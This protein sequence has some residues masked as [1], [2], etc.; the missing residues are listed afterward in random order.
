MEPKSTIKI[1]YLSTPGIGKKIIQG[2]NKEYKRNS[3]MHVNLNELNDESILKESSKEILKNLLE[4]RISL[5]KDKKNAKIT[6][7]D[8]AKYKSKLIP[9]ARDKA[10]EM[11]LDSCTIKKGNIL[12]LSAV[13]T[14][15]DRMRSND[16]RTAAPEDIMKILRGDVYPTDIWTDFGVVLYKENKDGPNKKHADHL[17]E[18]LDL[19]TNLP[20]L[21]YGLRAHKDKKFPYGVRLDFIPGKSHYFEAPVLFGGTHTPLTR[22]Q[23]IENVLSCPDINEDADLEVYANHSGLMP[24]CMD[25]D[26]NIGAVEENLANNNSMGRILLVKDL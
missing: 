8:I 17:K 1:S 19:R 12:Y 24:V 9:S 4:K 7:K 22:D 5:E 6:R 18:Q 21:I 26:R 15:L 2:I 11:Y 16:I 3:F 13:N 23:S 25:R 20:V 10:E 14:E